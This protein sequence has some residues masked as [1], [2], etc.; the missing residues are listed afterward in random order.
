M[1]VISTAA[2]WVGV[3]QLQ[4]TMEATADAH[5]QFKRDGRNQSFTD[6]HC[7]AQAQRLHYLCRVTDD[8]GLPEVHNLLAQAPK[9]QD[10]RILR[11]LLSD[12]AH[13]SAVPLTSVNAPKPTNKLT[14]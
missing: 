6:K 3:N 10:H 8:T 11:S 7:T 4:T 1:G 9:G 2:F 14:D 5:L 12:R 13:A